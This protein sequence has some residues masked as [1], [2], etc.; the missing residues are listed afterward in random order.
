MPDPTLDEFE[1]LL[2][3]LGK[4][5]HTAPRRDLFAGIEARIA[6]PE[7]AV[8]PL[9]QYRSLVAAAVLLLLLNLVALQ[10][11]VSAAATSDQSYALVTTYLYD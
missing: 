8:I 9:R 3:G 4:L 6:R 1:D 7:A 10:H 11:Y 2:S 5:P